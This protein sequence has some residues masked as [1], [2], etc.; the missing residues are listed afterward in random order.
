MINY[1][2]SARQHYKDLGLW[3]DKI[4]EKDI[5]KL[6]E[7][8]KDAIVESDYWIEINNPIINTKVGGKLSSAYIDGKSI[9]STESEEVVYL[10]GNEF[11]GFCDCADQSGTKVITKTFEKWCD[12]LIK[13]FENGKTK[14]SN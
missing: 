8:L 3:Y 10:W 4:S 9:K 5:I 7:M 13:G 11:I 1:R 12:Y 6:H 2:N 14:K